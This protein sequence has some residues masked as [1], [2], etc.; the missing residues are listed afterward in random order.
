MRLPRPVNVDWLVS[1]FCAGG[2]C[3]QVAAI[4]DAIAIRD[5]KNPDGPVL[6]Y[7]PE[8]WRDFLAGAKNGDFD[9]LE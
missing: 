3:V 6:R 2:N 5:S 9:S 8:E 4:G 1:T 7:S